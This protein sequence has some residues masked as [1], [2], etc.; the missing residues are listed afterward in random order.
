M[1]LVVGLGN[2]GREYEG[3]RHNVGWLLLDHLAQRWQLDDWRRDGE[4]RVADARFG[5]MRVRLLKPLTYMNL[6]G[7]VLRPYLRREPWSTASDLLVVLD[8]VALPLGRY[9]LRAQGSAGGHNGLKSV[10][11][12]VGS[13]DYARLRLGVGPE[14]PGRRGDLAD[15][16]LN[17]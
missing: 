2:P 1:K 5:N 15:Y 3:T 11:G 4:A 17:D 7:Q 16:V 9:R 12:A 8:E 13:Q 10:E 14:N 6:S